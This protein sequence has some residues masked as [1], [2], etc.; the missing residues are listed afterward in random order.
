[1]KKKIIKIDPKNGDFLVYTKEEY[2]TL[3]NKTDELIC[4]NCLRS[5]PNKSFFKKRGCIWCTL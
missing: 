3:E 5:L 1:M 4:P 2:L